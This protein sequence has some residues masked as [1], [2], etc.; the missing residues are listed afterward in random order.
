[1]I[2]LLV[3]HRDSPDRSACGLCALIHLRRE[4]VCHSMSI[5]AACLQSMCGLRYINTLDWRCRD[6]IWTIAAQSASPDLLE[7]LVQQEVEATATSKIVIASTRGECLCHS[8]H[9]VARHSLCP[10]C[11]TDRV[12][13]ACY[14]RIR[15]RCCLRCRSVGCSGAAAQGT[16]YRCELQG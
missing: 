5:H 6:S 4:A 11:L 13:N 2:V 12:F 1:M 16:G 10:P 7:Y 9:L 14:C 3:A 15:A 8:T